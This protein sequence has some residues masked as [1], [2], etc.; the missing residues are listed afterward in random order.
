[1]TARC[2]TALERSH[3]ACD[4]RA[5]L[6]ATRSIERLVMWKRDGLVLSALD[7]VRNSVDS[8]L[9]SLSAWI[10][11]VRAVKGC[12]SSESVAVSASGQ[13][14]VSLGSSC[15]QPLRIWCPKGRVREQV[16]NDTGNLCVRAWITLAPNCGRVWVH[17][18]R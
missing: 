7:S 10:L 17:S 5:A 16:L 18:V 12:M 1:M 13:K 8:R 6:G 3:V 4:E 9:N 2:D 11:S 15:A 14:N